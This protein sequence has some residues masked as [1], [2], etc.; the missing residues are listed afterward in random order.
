MLDKEMDEHLGYAKHDGAGDKTGNS[1]NG[2]TSKT[3]KSEWGE[4]PIKVPRDRNGTFIPSV[5]PKSQR[6]MESLD[7]QV[8]AMYRK[9][10]SDPKSPT[11]S[12]MFAEPSCR[13][14]W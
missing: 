6:R 3:L 14:A 2:Y 1:R 12:G 11:M 5:V 8:V 7:D 4:V 10:M 13:R 9:G